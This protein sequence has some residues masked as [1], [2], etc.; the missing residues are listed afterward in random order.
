MLRSPISVK[1][2]T[3]SDTKGEE[4]SSFCKDS[5]RFKRDDSGFITKLRRDGTPK[6]MWYKKLNRKKII[7]YQ[8]FDSIT[9]N[10]YCEVLAQELLRL[11]FSHQPKTRLLYDNDDK[12]LC[13]ISKKIANIDKP[14]S[15]LSPS[16]CF[17]YGGILVGILWVNDDDTHDG[18]YGVNEEE[19]IVKIDG[20]RAFADL[21]E[22]ELN[23]DDAEEVMAR[24]NS[25]I[26]KEVID[27]LPN[28]PPSY[29]YN[30][31]TLWDIPA[32]GK[33]EFARGI[34]AS[35]VKILT[36]PDLF[37]KEFISH[38]VPGK[39][40]CK[41]FHD[42]VIKRR[43][44]LLEAVRSNKSFQDYLISPQSTSDHA[45]YIEKLKNFKTIGKRCPFDA[46]FAM[47]M[48]DNYLALKK[49]FEASLSLPAGAA[50]GAAVVATSAFTAASLIASTTTTATVAL[51]S[52]E[53][54]AT[55][56]ESAATHFSSEAET[57]PE[58]YQEET[59]KGNKEA[60]FILACRLE[61]QREFV[62]AREAYRAA[63]SGHS[64]AR[65]RLFDPLFQKRVDSA[66]NEAEIKLKKKVL[67]LEHE[68]YVES[69]KTLINTQRKKAKKHATT[70][71][72]SLGFLSP[73][74]SP[75]APLLLS[76]LSP[77]RSVG[78]ENK[79]QKR[80]REDGFYL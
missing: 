2:P 44:M 70:L 55:A 72:P 57:D 12:V 65:A 10:Q 14:N 5:R 6:D 46:T 79:N 62:L 29:R 28:L 47:Q 69:V 8:V 16:Q 64:E 60:Q 42:E 26:T 22:I 36:F 38:Y 40:G 15:K 3:D 45:A 11:L 9:E 21:F 43:G 30:T 77:P 76:S 51:A 23:G 53:I 68:A 52:A 20:D 13:V 71:L 61:E 4:S 33:A 19:K 41:F 48:S 74:L 80:K 50:A 1:K 39:E 63:A 35:I 31:W 73:W 59:Q 49:S 67:E 66:E 32:E 18:N 7:D 58:Y 54:R 27:A 75:S 56:D 34:N 17:D 25:T 24:T 37:L 78:E